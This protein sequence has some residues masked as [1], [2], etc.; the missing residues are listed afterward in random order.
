MQGEI[1]GSGSSKQINSL[2][3]RASGERL[4]MNHSLHSRTWIY[5]LLIRTY[6]LWFL[7]HYFYPSVNQKLNI[8]LRGQ[9]GNL[10]HMVCFIC[11]DALCILKKRQ[12]WLRISLF[13]QFSESQTDVP[14]QYESKWLTL[15]AALFVQRRSCSRRQYWLDFFFNYWFAYLLTFLASGAN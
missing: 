4:E 5:P 13:L 14:I 1:G 2:S 15:P 3:V 10:V 6:G 9:L 7:H 11:C 12:P 8:N